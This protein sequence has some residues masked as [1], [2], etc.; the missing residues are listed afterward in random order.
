MKKKII[1]FIFMIVFVYALGGDL[2]YLLNRK[3]E[4]VKIS[5]LDSIK[6]YSYTLKSNDTNTYKKEF[7]S[8]KANLESDKVNDE[9]YAKSIA[10]MF[11]IDFYTLAN[12]INKYDVGGL[13]FVYPEHLSN[14]KVN[15]QNTIYKYLEDNSK[16]NRKQELPEVKEVE[17]LENEKMNYTIKGNSYNGY[18]YKL[19]WTYIKDL[20]YDSEGEVIVIKL[21]KNYYVVEKN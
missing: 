21:D 20:G 3:P 14:F 11:I 10:K 17:I 4:V 9:E 16:S 6:G 2:Y 15:A 8:L 1:L 13:S 18:K 12:K 5:S 19:K 7:E